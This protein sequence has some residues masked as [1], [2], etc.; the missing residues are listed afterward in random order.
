MGG[1]GDRDAYM[2]KRVGRSVEG[3]KGLNGLRAGSPP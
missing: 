2:D 1:L 3:S